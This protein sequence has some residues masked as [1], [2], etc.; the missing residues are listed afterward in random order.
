[1][2]LVTATPAI[3]GL[4]LAASI[5]AIASKAMKDVAAAT[6]TV[7]VTTDDLAYWMRLAF[8][9]GVLGGLRPWQ[10]RFADPRDRRARR[11]DAY[12]AKMRERALIRRR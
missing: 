4:R 7:R 6:N 12:N 8:D 2:R 11:R 3:D 1:V 5:N 9:S 10:R